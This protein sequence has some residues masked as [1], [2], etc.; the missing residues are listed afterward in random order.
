[1]SKRVGLVALV[2]LVAAAGTWLGA[3]EQQTASLPRSS[4]S[5]VP[6]AAKATCR[7]TSPITKLSDLK[8]KHKGQSSWRETVVKDGESIADYVS[9]APGTK[10]SPRL[11]PATPT[12]FVV[13]EGEMRWQIENQEHLPPSAV[14]WSTFRHGPSSRT[15]RRRGS[16]GLHRGE[17]R[18]LRARV[19]RD[20]SRACRAA[21]KGGHR[22]AVQ[23]AH[24]DPVCGAEQAA[25]QSARL[26][27]GWPWRRRLYQHASHV[28]QCQFW[29][30][31]S[32]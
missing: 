26:D 27:R 3:Q 8:A 10:L 4:G 9:M 2:A 19:S 25:L 23:R 21:G 28:C 32:Q 20:Q 6:R 14:R 31:R 17:R 13:F 29:I 11:H 16:G 18:P 5:S 24:T 22:N 30:R 1:M 15:R 7:P 12:L